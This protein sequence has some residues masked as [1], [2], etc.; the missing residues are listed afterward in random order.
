[1]KLLEQKNLYQPKKLTMNNTHNRNLAEQARKRRAM[2]LKVRDRMVRNGV[3]PHNATAMM[4]RD[5]GISRA[6]MY[7]LLTQAEGEVK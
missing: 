5:Y 7:D 2:Y 4:A 1:M 6:R 3:K